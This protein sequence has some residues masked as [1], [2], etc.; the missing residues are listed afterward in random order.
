MFARTAPLL[1]VVVTAALWGCGDDDRDRVQRYIA[2]ANAVQERFAPAFQQANAAYAGFAE[3]E[4][5]AKAADRELTAAEN[6]LR[7]ARAELARVEPPASAAQLHGSLLR[8]V[9]MNAEFAA[10]STALARY[11]PAARRVLRRA[12]AIGETLRRR[13]QA[14]DAPSAQAA[15]LS[16]YARGIAKRYDALYELEPPPILVPTQRAQLVRLSDSSRLARRLRSASEA[17]DSARVARLLLEFRAV[18]RRSDS[19]GLT[20]RA[21]REYNE[22]YGAIGEAAAAVRREQGRLQQRLG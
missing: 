6:A 1:V 11:L 12:G 7:D 20:R 18:S 22:R 10:E 4:L 9:D 5:S 13:L 16:R 8:V 21:V 19:A 2:R 15:A 3:G 14:A 17:R